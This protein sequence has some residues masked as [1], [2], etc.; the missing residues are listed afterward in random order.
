MVE[1][2]IL[3]LI[4]ALFLGLL[5]GLAKVSPSPILRGIATTYTTVIREVPDLVL[6][7]LFFFGGQML[8]NSFSDWL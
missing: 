5:G 1:V 7:I 2:A 4:L 3:S 8:M 6:M